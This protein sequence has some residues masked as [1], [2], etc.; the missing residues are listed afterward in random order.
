MSNVVT[1]ITTHA[2]D[3]K[4]RLLQQFKSKARIAALLDAINAQNQEIEDAGQELSDLLDIDVMTGV[5]LDNIGEIVAQPR[6]GRSDS[7]YRQAIREKIRANVSSGTPD[8]IIEAFEFI[9]SPTTVDYSE[10]PPA[11]F[12][13]YGDGSQPASLFDAMNAVKPAGVYM[14][15]LDFLE[16]EDSDGALWED[17]DTIY[18]IYASTGR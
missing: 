5:N 6:E 14:G 13:I 17:S 8:E 9:T 4:A 7:D 1:P 11:G 12:V 10:D 2:A 16:W 3:A 18:V 15:L